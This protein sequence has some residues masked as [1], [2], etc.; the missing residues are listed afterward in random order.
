MNVL[1]GYSWMSEVT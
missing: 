1:H